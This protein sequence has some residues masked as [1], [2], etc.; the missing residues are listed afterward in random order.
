MAKQDYIT[1]GEIYREHGLKGAV[2]V[3]MYS[4]SDENLFA[5]QQYHLIAEDGRTLE[6]TPQSLQSQGQYFLIHFDKISTPEEAKSWR[7][8]KFQIPKAVLLEQ[9]DDD[10]MYDFEWQDFAVQNED[11]EEIGK[12]LRIDYSPLRQLVVAHG[13]REVLIPHVQEWV[14]D[15]DED[16]KVI[17]MQLP[18]GLLDD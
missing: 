9:K 6:V 5:D 17:K 12:V 8:A 18:E 1:I 13:G 4:G 10:E 14:L 2:K 15:L 7:K 3:Y 11:G 16:A